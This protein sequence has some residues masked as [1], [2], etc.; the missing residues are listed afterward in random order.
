[1]YTKSKHKQTLHKEK[2]IIFA[3]EKANKLNKLMTK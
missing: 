1:M 2:N 3:V